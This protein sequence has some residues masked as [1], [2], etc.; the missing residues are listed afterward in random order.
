MYDI[1][2]FKYILKEYWYQS[3]SMI[4]YLLKCNSSPITT[5][6]TSSSSFDIQD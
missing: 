2:Y 4:P 6:T 1:L 5:T 3:I